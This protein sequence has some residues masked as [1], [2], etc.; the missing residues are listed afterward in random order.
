MTDNK[1]RNLIERIKK[2]AVAI[3]LG[4][5]YGSYRNALSI[6]NMEAL[7]DRRHNLCVKFA[8]KSLKH[9]KYNYWFCSNE[10]TRNKNC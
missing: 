4:S 5:D 6:L 10:E 9:E 8:Q 7:G 2:T 1:E 3:I